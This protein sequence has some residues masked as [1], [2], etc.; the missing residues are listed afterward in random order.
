MVEPYK[1][2]SAGIF[3]TALTI[4]GVITANAHHSS[5][6]HFDNT[7][8]I[9]K[10][11]IVTEWQ[12]VNPHSY[13]YFDVTQADGSVVNWRCEGSAA[14]TLTRLNYTEDTFVPGM[15]ITVS[16]YPA[17]REDNVCLLVNLAFDDGTVISRNGPLPTDRIQGQ[18]FVE[19]ELDTTHEPFLAN[20]TPNFAG[21]WVAERGGSPGGPP[22]GG[23]GMGGGSMGPPDGG[24]MGPPDGGGMSGGM[25]GGMGPPDGPGRIQLTAAGQA[26]EDKYDQIYDDPSI[27]CGI[28]NIIFGMGHDQ[29]VN[30]I[31][32]A[33]DKLTIL[34]GFMDFTRE[35][36]LDRRDFPANLT[37]S[38]GGYSIGHFEGDTLVVN[39][40]GFTPSVI[41]PLTGGSFS[42][43]TQIT[44]RFKYDAAS[45]AILRDYTLTDPKYIV[46]E[47]TGSDH[48][49]KS[50][51]PYTPYNCVELSGINNL[52]PGTPEYQ[53]EYERLQ[54]QGLSVSGANAGASAGTDSNAHIVKNT[55][56][57]SAPSKILAIILAIASLL[58]ALW[59]FSLFR[60]SQKK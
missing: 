43:Q 15:K 1:L 11:G 21:F 25:G 53:A 51:R 33:E 54:A 45:N 50:T 52:R 16:G 12:F 8:N 28:T 42:E 24:N 39:S 60:R 27:K 44:E 4:G 37:L 23:G 7:I 9:E 2:L 35:I 29:N 49:V 56:K 18:A 40:K 48:F 13:I 10:T 55:T 6:P 34:Y 31:T 36:Y 32:Q 30:Q 17:R 58:I 41:Q 5:T 26:A 57:G 47:V 38:E 22:N 19:S 14:S 59:G 3:C 46:G 20:G